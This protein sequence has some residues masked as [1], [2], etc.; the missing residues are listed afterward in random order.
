V[1]APREITTVG[2]VQ[3]EVEKRGDERA[4]F[5]QMTNLNAGMSFTNGSEKKKVQLCAGRYGWVF[6]LWLLPV[7]P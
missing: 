2:V 6:I 1:A 5:M 7:S 3:L 4:S